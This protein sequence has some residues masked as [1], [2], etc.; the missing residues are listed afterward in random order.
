MGSPITFSGFNGIDFNTILN[1]VMQQASAPLTALQSRQDDFKSQLTAFGKLTSQASTLQQAAKDLQ[2]STSGDIVAASTTDASAVAVSTGTGA[3]PGRYDVVVQALAHAQ[4]TAS[5]STTPDVNTTVV[6]TGGALTIGGVA[7]NISGPVTLQQLATA[8]NGTADIGVAASVVQSS[9]GAYRLVLTGKDT[10]A[11]QSFAVD[12]TLTGSSLAFGGNAVEATDASVLVNNVQ[13]VSS[14]NTFEGAVPGVTLTVLKADAVNT[15]G[16]NVT[17]SSAALK[18][19]IDAFV[20]SYND[21]VSFT[22][23][24][25]AQR[26]KGDNGNLARDPMLR[27]MGQSV[28]AALTAGYGSGSVDRLSQLGL[29]FTQSG[30]LK[31]DGTKLT[32]ALTADPDA[33]LGLVS[34]TSGAFGA[35]QSMLETYTNSGGLL[36]T[37]TGQLNTQIRSLDSQ[38]AKAQDRLNIYRQNMQQEFTAAEMAMS[39]LQSQSSALS[40]AGQ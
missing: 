40:G 12:N 20:K 37:S 15:I 6:A 23:D 18:T 3:V 31:I 10:G 16:V 35:I 8:I 11:D 4:V 26:A 19:R 38:L 36:Q 34:G 17:T 5:T 21:L 13:A 14:T 1:S 24:Q 27:Q 9:V 33:V 7:V 39:R 2:N 29:E 28:R 25:Q 22:N 30:T 32:A